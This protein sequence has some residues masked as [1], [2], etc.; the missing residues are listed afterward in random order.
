MSS[1]WAG[2]PPP[3]S[4]PALVDLPDLPHAWSTPLLWV[5]DTIR[6]LMVVASLYLVYLLAFAALRAIAY[7]RALTASFLLAVLL[8]V[9][10]QVER[11]GRPLSWRAPL[12]LL[13]LALGIYGALRYMTGGYRLRDFTVSSFFLPPPPRAPQ[14]PD[15]SGRLRKPRPPP[16]QGRN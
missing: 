16:P 5:F 12:V 2:Q 9:W 11:I 13:M 1:A 8:S 7:Q 10:T 3:E 15:V 4:P 14:P 6:V